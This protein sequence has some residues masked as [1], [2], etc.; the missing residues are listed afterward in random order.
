[1]AMMSA[2]PSDGRQPSADCLLPQSLS[3]FRQPLSDAPW[4]TR[5]EQGGGWGGCGEGCSTGSGTACGRGLRPS[6]CDSCLDVG[7]A[8]WLYT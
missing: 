4:G 1:M 2:D 7:D 8:T 3:G 6:C 5:A